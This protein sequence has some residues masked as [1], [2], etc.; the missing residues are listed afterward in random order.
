M[1]E[2][3]EAFDRAF[4]RARAG[5]GARAGAF[6]V[7]DRVRYAE[8]EDVLD[9]GTIREIDPVGRYLV[10]WDDNP[11]FNGLQLPA[12][13]LVPASTPRTDGTDGE[14]YRVRD[15]ASTATIERIRAA[16][17]DPGRFCRRATSFPPPLRQLEPVD[18]WQARAVAIALEVL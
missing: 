3:L 17:R 14:G 6:K 13:W 12:R 7:G 5:A 2:P 4:G 9:A 11:Q 8:D 15:P 16:L 1:P 10:D 18:R